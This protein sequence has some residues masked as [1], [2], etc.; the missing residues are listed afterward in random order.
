MLRSNSPLEDK[1]VSWPHSLPAD[2]QQEAA[3]VVNWGLQRWC[4]VLGWQ[5]NVDPQAVSLYHFLSVTGTN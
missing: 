5:Q 1:A 3:N 4:L 2:L